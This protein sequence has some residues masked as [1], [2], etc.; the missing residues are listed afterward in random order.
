MWRLHK[1]NPMTVFIPFHG[2]LLPGAGRT[3]QLAE[4]QLQWQK[5]GG[6]LENTEGQSG[7]S[8]HD[9]GP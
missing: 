3:S 8:V 2:Q 5:S 6:S 4:A 9:R 1:V 7:F